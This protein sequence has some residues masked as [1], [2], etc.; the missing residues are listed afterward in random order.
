LARY[1]PGLDIDWEDLRLAVVY[2]KYRGRLTYEQIRVQA[3]VSETLLVRFLR[4]HQTLSAASFMRLIK[5][6]GVKAEDFVR[7]EK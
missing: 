5:W 1:I 3:G 4:H 7:E 2:A 6:L